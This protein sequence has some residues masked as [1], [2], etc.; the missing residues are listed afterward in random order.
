MHIKKLDEAMK[1]KAAIYTRVSTI[2]QTNDLQLE[3]LKEIA[4]KSN[5]D[6]VQIITEKVSGARGRS[7]RKGL[8]DLLT[9]VTKREVQVILI[10]AIDRLG[11]SLTDL[12][13]TMDTINSAGADLYIHTQGID[14]SLPAGR[15]MFQMVGVFAEFERSMIQERVKAGIAVA[16]RKGQK[17]GRP[18]VKKSVVR[19]VARF[20]EEGLTIRKTAKKVQTSTGTVNKVK[21]AIIEVKTGGP[22]DKSLE[23]LTNILKDE[24]KRGTTFKIAEIGTQNSRVKKAEDQKIKHG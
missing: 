16:R 18:T 8:D 13:A 12:V 20:L 21:K 19:K 22:P 23:R 14:T 4:K 1:M 11:R 7:G 15:M 9:A 5:W 24:I 3:T 2:E 6:V 17:W 10:W